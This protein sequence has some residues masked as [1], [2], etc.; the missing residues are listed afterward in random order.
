MKVLLF[1]EWENPK[2]EERRKKYAELTTAGT[3]AEQFK[4]LGASPSAWAD[5][6]GHI[7]SIIEFNSMEDFTTIWNDFEWHRW[8]AQF[9]R[10]V[11]NFRIRICRPAGIHPVTL[12][13]MEG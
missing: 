4:K 9:Y 2:D 12:E 10:A 13:K 7:V 6:T 5:G 3:F 11:D 8:H 1:R